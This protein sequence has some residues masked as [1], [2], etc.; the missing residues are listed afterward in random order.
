MI[1]SDQ[2]GYENVHADMPDV[3]GVTWPQPASPKM[4]HEIPDYSKQRSGPGE[5]GAAVYLSGKEKEQGDADMKKW[6]MNVV[7][8][9]KYIKA[10]ISELLVSSIYVSTNPL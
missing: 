9:A 2:P 4:K 7:A 8:R 5:N 6:F 3:F 1:G 10:S